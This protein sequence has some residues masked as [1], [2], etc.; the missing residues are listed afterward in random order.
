MTVQTLPIPQFNPKA[1]M[2]AV[3]LGA[4]KS[5]LMVVDNALLNP[6]DIVDHAVH[7]SNFVSPDWGFYPGYTASLDKK[8]IYSVILPMRALLK[9]VFGVPEAMPLAF[10]GYF[11]LVTLPPEALKPIQTVPHVDTNSSTQ[12]AI[13]LHLS[14][15]PRGGTAFYRHKATGFETID[16]TRTPRFTAAREVEFLA[17]RDRPARYMAGTDDQYEQLAAVEARFNRMIVYHSNLL[18]SGLCEPEKLSNDP[19][20]GRLTMNIF[21]NPKRPGT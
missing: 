14:D 20:T 1:R 21:I 5:R 19:R 15:P 12:L 16:K 4:D 8:L 2:Q 9:T 11:A 13:L 6:T 7:N 10:S 17:R 18:H 3:D